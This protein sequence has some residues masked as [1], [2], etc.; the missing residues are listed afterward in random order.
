MFLDIILDVLLKKLL[1]I[2]IFLE[3]GVDEDERKIFGLIPKERKRMH[4]MAMKTAIK[5]T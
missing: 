5:L 3:D 4:A 1:Q 2:T